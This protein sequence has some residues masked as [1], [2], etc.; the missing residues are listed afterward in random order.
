[1]SLIHSPGN[2]NTGETS[3][4]VGI[5]FIWDLLDLESIIPELVTSWSVINS[6]EGRGQ[7]ISA[8]DTASGP[9]MVVFAY[10]IGKDF[11]DMNLEIRYDLE[12]L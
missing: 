10:F 5:D 2:T 12:A 3:D 11:R 7:L 6:I 8:K 9:M 1:M 4:P